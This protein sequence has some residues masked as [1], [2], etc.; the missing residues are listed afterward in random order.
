MRLWRVMQCLA[1]GP[2][3]SDGLCLSGC[4][5]P[6]LD[7]ARRDFYSGQVQQRPPPDTTR[8]RTTAAA[9]PD[10]TR[11]DPPGRRRYAES[12]R[13]FIEAS[14]SWSSCDIQLS[15]GA[16]SMVANDTVENFRGAPYERTLL[17][18]LPPRT[19]WRRRTG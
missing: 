3:R 15:K 5:T 11:A 14:I 8:W 6:T 17:H 18:V 9:L 10:G 13:D 16:A 1:P 7:A 12:S 4:A 19:T 2:G